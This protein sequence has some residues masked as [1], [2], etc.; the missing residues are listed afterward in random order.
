MPLKRGS[1]G[2]L[3]VRANGVMGNQTLI[4]V[5]ITLNSDGTSQVQA[6]SGFESAGNDIANYVDQRFRMLLNKSLSQGGT[7]NRAIKGSR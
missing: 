7:L 1:D 2:S 5:D 4:N 3:G 6:T